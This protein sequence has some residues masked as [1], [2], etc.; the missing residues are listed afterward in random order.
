MDGRGGRG[1]GGH[2]L[3]RRLLRVALRAY[4]RGQ[5]ERDGEEVEAAAVQALARR[6]R[7]G[8]V[9]AVV[10]AGRMLWDV[11]T[12]G[13]TERFRGR[14]KR[15]GGMMWSDGW[16][17]LKLAVRTLAR[18][19][20][21]ALSAVMVLTLGIGANVV[22]FS[23][24][25]STLLAPP[26]YPEPD[27]L[28]FLEITE[29]VTDR[30]GPPRAFPWSYPKFQVLQGQASL[31]VEDA[32][33]YAVRPLTLTGAGDA[34]RLDAE[35]VTPGYFSILG[36]T[37]VVGRAFTEEDNAPE[38]TPVAV[39]GHGLW[40]DNFGSDRSVVG[41]DVTLNGR[42]VR[43]V[44][45]AP[46]G[47][48]G[49]SGS[50]RLWVTVAGGATLISPVLIR[51]AQAHWLNVVA[52]MQAT[53]DVATVATRMADVGQRVEEEY[54]TSDPT[55][56]RGGSATSLVEARVNPEARTAL[57]VLAAASLLLLL[58]ACANLAGLLVARAHSRS[59]DSA[60]RSALGAG[61]W[62]VAR[63]HVLEALVL[64]AAGCA[65][66][67]LAADAGLGALGSLWPDRFADAGW[68]VGA[69]GVD[70]LGVDPASVGFAVVVA[71][72]TTLLMGAIPA[73]VAS[74]SAPA[75]GLR[76]RS[77]GRRPGLFGDVRSL[78]VVGEI[79]VA[80]T[81]VVG[82]GLLL[83]SLAELGRVD[84]GFE[85]ESLVT[86]DYDI[87][88][89]SGW[90]EDPASFHEELLRRLDSDPTVASAALTCVP[91]LAGHCWIGGVREAGD[92]SYPEGS[93]PSIG[94]HPVSDGFFETLGVPVV[95]GRSFTGEDQADSRPVVVLSEAAVRE[96]FP[97]DP[98]PLGRTV[99]VT[100]SLTPE[101]GPSAEVVG[102]VE[103][104]L[105][106]RPAN[107]IMPELFVS[108]RQEDG[109][110][111]V[112]AR[113]RGEP[114]AVVARARTI[115]A[116]L[117]PNVPLYRVRTLDQLETDAAGDTRVLGM[118]LTG[119]ALLALILACTGV[120]A[121]VSFTVSRRTREIGVRVALGADRSSVIRSVQRRAVA[122]GVVGVVLGGALAYG[123]SGLLSS[124]VYGVG[125]AD[126]V[127]FA[128]A[129]ATLMT[130][131][132]VASWLPARRA[133]RVDPMEALRAE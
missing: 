76:S 119:F 117:D 23:A 114:E 86:F 26:P 108:H 104:I 45:V 107:G 60:V 89:G 31:P 37:P 2:G 79:A 133:T 24:V 77:H 48:D 41:R 127:A 51:G 85:A 88:R 96:L 9:G 53:T 4:P 74:R 38:S 62:R 32:A 6:R 44:G 123:L 29:S 80:L 25:R 22:V 67:L 113:P 126:P 47:F 58:V 28:V 64:S 75:S 120:W 57:L 100:M 72:L 81:L 91:P 21:F 54:P 68:N 52:R 3:F 46:P 1:D 56:V 55:V 129:A 19:P 17:D 105:F 116:E 97:D 118:L 14:E 125:T 102:V 10:L 130:V 92:R 8:R 39:L 5:R 111:T 95:M 121:I 16:L 30:P 11:T 34:V 59:R 87:P 18:S 106:D 49:L 112:V 93:R 27:R 94:I 124:V 33:A 71:L 128:A 90:S 65:V 84:R 42:A 36:V 69:A 101:E 20:G 115:L 109:T 40:T 35:V 132:L 83:R 122:A 110:G 13:I 78:L 15:G 61:R 103:D 131:S 82:A 70:A 12:S 99:S 7:E 66:A 73:V 63:S 98:D 50:G 43:V